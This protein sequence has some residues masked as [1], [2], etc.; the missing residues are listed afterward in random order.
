V[1]TESSV[2]ELFGVAADFGL[3][4]A[5]TFVPGKFLFRVNFFTALAFFALSIEFENMKVEPLELK[6]RAEGS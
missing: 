1:R 6:A 4:L 5:R 2:Q 3:L